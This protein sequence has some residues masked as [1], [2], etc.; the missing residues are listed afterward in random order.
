VGRS[1]GLWPWLQVGDY[2]CFTGARWDYL[3]KFRPGGEMEIKIQIRACFSR[4][5]TVIPSNYAKKARCKG[6]NCLCLL[7]LQSQGNLGRAW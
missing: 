4:W 2:G 3:L 5:E 6:T 1:W 7:Y